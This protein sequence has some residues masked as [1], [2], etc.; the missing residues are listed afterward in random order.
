MVDDLGADRGRSRTDADKDF[1]RLLEG[2]TP[3]Q[4]DWLA[5]RLDARSDREASREAGIGKSVPSLWKAD[6]V[7]LD[8][9][10]IAAKQ[11]GVI[12]VRRRIRADL[13]WA[14]DVKRSGLRSQD[15][16]VQQAAST[17]I[18]DRGL[19]KA[20]QPTESKAEHTVRLVLDDLD[21]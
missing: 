12:L 14:Y 15:E 2:L 17:E 20:T 11:D 10:I 21:E 4:L 9:I 6:G 1:D 13:N 5:C 7:P 8:E 19:G 18:M 16:K 3:L